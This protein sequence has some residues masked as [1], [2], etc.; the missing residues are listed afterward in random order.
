MIKRKTQKYGG[1]TTKEKL[2]SSEMPIQVRNHDS[3][4]AV[5]YTALQF[6]LHHCSAA[7]ELMWMNTYTYIPVFIW[8]CQQVKLKIIK[9]EMDGSG[10]CF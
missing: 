8:T 1:E 6:F 2:A 5:D 7:W 4:G 3:G 10:R 9:E